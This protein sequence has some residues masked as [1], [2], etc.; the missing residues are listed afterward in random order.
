[1]LP[2]RLLEGRLFNA[3]C[4]QT[5]PQLLGG[6]RPWKTSQASHTSVRLTMLME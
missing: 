6:S 2:G 1:M 3:Q 4:S 5:L